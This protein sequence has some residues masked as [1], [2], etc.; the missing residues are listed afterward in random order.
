M[1]IKIRDNK[2]FTLVELLVVMTILV[3]LTTMMIGIFNAIGITNKGR[4]AQRKKDLNRIKVAFEE[5]LTINKF[6]IGFSFEFNE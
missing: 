1:S 6:L 2:A 4:D 5:Y 3:I